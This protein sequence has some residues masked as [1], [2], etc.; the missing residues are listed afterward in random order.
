MPSSLSID[1]IARLGAQQ[2]IKM[3]LEAEIHYLMVE[4][5]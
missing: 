1:E 3:Y 5:N 2:I 4:K